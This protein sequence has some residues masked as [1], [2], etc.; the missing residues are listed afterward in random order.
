MAGVGRFQPLEEDFFEA[1]V[2]RG[3]L[4][5]AV[6]LVGLGAR[7]EV[8][9]RDRRP[10]EAPAPA[11]HVEQRVDHRQAE[12]ADEAVLEE[13]VAPLLGVLALLA[14][15]VDGHGGRQH[16]GGRHAAAVDA[17]L[18]G[19][20]LGVDDV[21]VV[22]HRLEGVLEAVA[23]GPPAA[24]RL[25]E[26]REVERAVLA[27]AAEERPALVGPA[28]GAGQRRAGLE[29]HVRVA[30]GAVVPQERRGDVAPHGARDAEPLGC[31]AELDVRRREHGRAEG[32]VAGVGDDDRALAADVGGAVGGVERALAVAAD[33]GPRD[34]PAGRDVLRRAL[35]GLGQRRER[36]RVGLPARR[37]REQ[38]AARRLAGVARGREH[39]EGAVLAVDGGGVDAAA[40]AVDHEPDALEVGDVG[41]PEGRAVAVAGADEQGHGRVDDERRARVDRAERRGRRDAPLE[42]R[43]PRRDERR[44]AHG[45]AHELRR[46]LPGPREEEAHGERR[47]E[48]AP[49]LPL[50]RRAA[51]EAPGARGAKG[52]RRVGRRLRRARRREAR[53]GP[54]PRRR[55]RAEPEARRD[56]RVVALRRA[57]GDAREVRLGGARLRRLLRPRLELLDVA[58]HAERRRA[59]ARLLDGERQRLAPL[60][61][62]VPAR[63]ADRRAGEL[64]A[65][66]GAAARGE[67]LVLDARR[68]RVAEGV[69]GAAGGRRRGRARGR[70]EGGHGL[71][72]RH[73][74]HGHGRVHVHH[75]AAAAAH[76][77]RHGAARCG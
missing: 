71:H 73:G 16:D 21:L 76:L 43:R 62:R 38:G 34:G 68:P 74:L 45:R 59:R 25:L 22:V 67:G 75:R 33:D 20:A 30:R 46:A 72:V 7:V 44:A 13:P 40:A 50:V 51:V 39:L 66:A 49:L 32:R 18:D 77:E 60:L 65:E 53:A 35:R 64:D 23:H 47:V 37:Q 14:L 29:E 28:R 2:L 5:G 69:D 27:A 4:L 63:R 57:D 10:R 54:G 41:D 15:R 9:E 6:D 8:A 36:G 58:G 19:R 56:D 31:A 70:L 61:L 42:G 24:V 26:E 55:A 52:R 3:D 1:I 17:V 11:L 12:E 48:R